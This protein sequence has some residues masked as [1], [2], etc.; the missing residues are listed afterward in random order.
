MKLSL[1]IITLLSCFVSAFASDSDVCQGRLTVESGIPIVT[2]SKTEANTLYFTPFEGEKISL[3]IDSHWIDVSFKEVSLSLKQLEANKNYD[4]FVFLSE[5]FLTLEISQAWTHDS[6]RAE[7][8][9]KQNGI[10]VKANQPSHRYVGTF[11]TVSANATEDSELR[12]FVWNEC[13]KTVHRLEVADI[14]D[15]WNYE[16]NDFRLVNNKTENRLEFVIGGTGTTELRARAV[17]NVKNPLSLPV[18]THVGLDQ[19]LPVIPSVQGETLLQTG[20][21]QLT[22]EVDFHPGLGFHQLNWLESGAKDVTFFGSG[23]AGAPSSHL[24]AKLL[25]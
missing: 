18:Q 10:L 17:L 4:V 24:S 13:N 3:F 19:L 21:Y 6:L 8:L 23:I 5:G 16:L 12:R 22:T 7:A 20:I 9:G 15:Q 25:Y 14:T 11:R 1:F 2:G